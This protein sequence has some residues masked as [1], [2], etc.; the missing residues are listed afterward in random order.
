MPINNLALAEQ[1]GFTKMASPCAACFSRFKG[2]ARHH[3]EDGELADKIGE[4]SG[5][6]YQDSVEVL[7][8]TQCLEQ[9]AA[10]KIEG[11]LKR[12]LDGQKVAC[13][14]G[15]LLTRPPR[16]TGETEIENPTD[17]E[18]LVRAMG[19]VPMEWG[20]KTDC[21]GGSL[22]VTHPEQAKKM[23]ADILIEA[24]A[25]ESPMYC[26]AI[27]ALRR[28]VLFLL[29]K[30]AIS[31]RVAE[32]PRAWLELRTKSARV[33]PLLEQRALPNVV[34][35]YSFTPAAAHER[36]EGSVPSVE[37]RVACMR[38]LGERGWPLGLRFDPLIW[39]D[40]YREA[41]LELFET[42][43][44]ELEADWIH[45]VSLGAFRMPQRFLDRITGQYPEEPLFAGPLERC[46][47]MASYRSD[48]EQ[49]MLEFCNTELAGFVPSERFFPCVPG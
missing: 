33:A 13:Y 43:F 23:T 20:R 7:H 26:S 35:A 12:S 19:G 32:R 49:E 46:D 44:S 22:A 40:G 25:R 9:M 36:L 2:A 4:A 39:W 8:T 41:Y 21:C 18:Q 38:E 48:I 15:C 5:Y 37:R 29:C 1:A 27:A 10:D 24:K 16:D 14:Y 6:R 45:S 47:G 31:G 34:A 11:A 30:Q 17:M 42:V 28:R 3:K